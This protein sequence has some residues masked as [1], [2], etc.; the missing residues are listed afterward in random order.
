VFR[1]R[2]LG[3]KRALIARGTSIYSFLLPVEVTAFQRR[4]IK[5][6]A[7]YI[8]APIT[9]MK[10]RRRV[11]CRLFVV[12]SARINERNLV[13]DDKYTSRCLDDCF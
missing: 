12:I 11:R 2:N 3:A 9:D 13:N 4:R 7:R 10:A 5:I 6:Q 8:N 1:G